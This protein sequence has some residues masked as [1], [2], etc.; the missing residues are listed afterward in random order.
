MN[1]RNAPLVRDMDPSIPAKMQDADAPQ[2]TRIGA[3]RESQDW[4]Y[5]EIR[6]KNIARCAIIIPVICMFA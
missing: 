5:A 4:L 6:A 2:S 3:R 1:R